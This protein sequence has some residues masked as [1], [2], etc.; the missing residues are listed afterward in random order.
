MGCHHLENI[1]HPW[2]NRQIS[3]A[4]GAPDLPHV[5]F[6]QT[7][8][9]TESLTSMSCFCVVPPAP[10]VV[11]LGR[12]PGKRALLLVQQV[13]AFPFSLFLVAGRAARE[14]L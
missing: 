3:L 14:G 10:Y 13:K 11:G 6:S 1:A 8:P 4:K 12:G 7:P 2:G 5:Q 9:T